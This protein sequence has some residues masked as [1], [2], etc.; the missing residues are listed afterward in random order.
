MVHRPEG[1]RRPRPQRPTGRI[2]A[3]DPSSGDGELVI[4]LGPVFPNGIAFLADGT[5]VWTESFSRRVMAL[6][7]GAAEVVVELPER[8][9]PRR[10]LHR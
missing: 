10:A 4:E 8:H 3:V 7:D 2:F 5:L 9:S 1:G 6:V